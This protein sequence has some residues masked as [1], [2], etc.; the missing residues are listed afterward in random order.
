MHDVRHCCGADPAVHCRFRR[1]FVTRLSSCGEQG[2]PNHETSDHKT[3]CVM[4]SWLVGYSVGT[5]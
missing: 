2:L 4:L 5:T 3:V 1:I